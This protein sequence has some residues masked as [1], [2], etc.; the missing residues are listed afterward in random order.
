M[1]LPIFLQQ[2]FEHLLIKMRMPELTDEDINQKIAVS[3]QPFNGKITFDNQ[4]LQQRFHG[5]FM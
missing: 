3:V 1:I 2:L 5:G 4:K